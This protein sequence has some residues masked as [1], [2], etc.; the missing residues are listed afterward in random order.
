[1]SERLTQDDKPV[2]ILAPD[3]TLVGELPDDISAADLQ[4]MYRQMVLLR[5]FDQR[6]LALQRQGRLG[7]YAPL[8]GQEACQVGSVRALAPSDWLVPTYRDSGALLLKGVPMQQVLQY[9][10]GDEAGNRRPPGV[11]VFPIAILI[12]TQVIHGAGLAWAQKLRRTGAIS[13]T[14]LGDG[15]TSEGD[16]HE[17]L[18]FAAVFGLPAVF[19]CENNQWAISVPASRQFAT[20]TVA[21]K[22][23]AYGM[24]GVRVDGNDV[25]A[26]YAAASAAVRRAR[27]ESLP[28]LIEGLTY[29][30]G[31]HTTA[32]DPT[33]YRSKEEEERWLHERDPIDRLRRYLTAAGLWDDAQEQEL[34][35]EARAQVGEAVAG[36]EQA[37]PPDPARIFA[38]VYAEMPPLLAAQQDELQRHLQRRR[39]QTS[40]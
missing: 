37:P 1:M 2:Q 3:G 9:W 24:C 32:D 18:N 13:F 6:A 31:P 36:L 38:H 22:A 5:I 10:A 7:T 28:T 27:T 29:R 35:T 19:F 34:L 11:N 39:A 17:G 25:L 21:E 14:F 20:A 16:F 40:E 26:V 15:A 8:S 23:A 33:R 4:Q 30:Q 12:A